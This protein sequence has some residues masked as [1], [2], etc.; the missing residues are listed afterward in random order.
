MA[1]ALLKLTLIPGNGMVH[2][3]QQGVELGGT[4][5][6]IG[7]PVSIQIATATGDDAPA[8]TEPP[9]GS[10]AGIERNVP[11]PPPA[12]SPAGGSSAGR[13]AQL[14]RAGWRSTTSASRRQWACSPTGATTINLSAAQRAMARAANSAV[15]VF[16]SPISSARTAPRSCQ[17]PTGPAALMGQRTSAV[18]QRHLQISSR[19][20]ITVGWQRR[21][22]ADGTNPTIAAT[23]G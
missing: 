8:A 20:Q 10:P 6:F 14:T 16:P 4:T 9:C 7:V 15:N 12:V 1:I 23:G 19:H 11:H 5:V 18:P 17:K 2:R 3:R 21:A 13:R 22:T